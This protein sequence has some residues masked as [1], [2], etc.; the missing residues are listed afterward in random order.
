V[1]SGPD[2][3]TY[4][5]YY[6]LHV[7]RPYQMRL[8]HGGSRDV[9]ALSSSLQ[10]QPSTTPSLRLHA[11]S[12]FVLPHTWL[13]LS[14]L[15]PLVHGAAAR[16]QQEYLHRLSVLISF[17]HSH[18]SA[19]SRLPAVPASPSRPLPRPGVPWRLWV[20]AQCTTSRTLHRGICT[21]YSCQSA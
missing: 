6:S 4:R 1:A 7:P 5:I 14:T 12:S 10:P 8:F 9:Y 17:L 21:N 13:M 2:L 20:F 3:Q 16:V 19:L 18:A 15:L 11:S